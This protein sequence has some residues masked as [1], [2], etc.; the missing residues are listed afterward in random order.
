MK[1]IL[2]KIV[3]VFFLLSQPSFWNPAELNWS[4]YW[5]QF[6]DKKLI[7]AF[8]FVK[9]I[10]SKCG[11]KTALACIHKFDTEV[12]YRQIVSENTGWTT[13]KGIHAFNEVLAHENEHIKINNEL[14]PNGY[15]KSLDLDT[16]LYPDWWENGPG[17]AFRFLTNWHCDLYSKE[18]GCENVQDVNWLENPRN[19]AGYRYEETRCVNVQKNAIVNGNDG[20]DWSF[21]PINKFQ[22]KNLK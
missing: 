2:N 6:V 16:D 7:T 12:Y 11:R 20:N 8:T 15:D 4:Y 21:D 13:N 1:H 5:K 18:A 22:G 3:Q 19:S 14:W 10:E 17:A 9:D